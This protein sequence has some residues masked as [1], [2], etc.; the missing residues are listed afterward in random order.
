MAKVVKHSRPGSGKKVSEARKRMWR[1][2]ATRWTRVGQ[3]EMWGDVLI[4]RAKRKP[5]QYKLEQSDINGVMIEAALIKAPKLERGWYLLLPGGGER[6]FR[7]KRRAL[8]FFSRLQH[9]PDTEPD[10]EDHMK[11]GLG[12]PIRPGGTMANATDEQLADTGQLPALPT[13]AG[14]EPE[15]P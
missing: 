1:E 2:S 14:G 8:D 12:N 11:D 13:D 9:I 5:P 3:E 10:I 7:T 15:L 6:H 4:L